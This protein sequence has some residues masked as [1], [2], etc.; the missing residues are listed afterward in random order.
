[1]I[2]NYKIWI[3]VGIIFIIY[4]VITILI[5]SQDSKAQS[6]TWT[7]QTLKEYT[8]M[9]FDA[10]ALAITQKEN[11]YN[12]RFDNT[13][14]WRSSYDDLIRRMEVLIQTMQ[15]DYIPRTEYLKLEKELT[16]QKARFDKYEN[17]KQGGNNILYLIIAII[18][19][20]VAFIALSK[21]FISS[22]Y[23]SNK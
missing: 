12:K 17:L 13:N 7:V 21:N 15:R 16:E 8:D 10:L 4:F 9:R 14:E 18:S 11:D 3:G 6:S 22:I 1:M 23:K 19:S 2:K 20:L 5:T